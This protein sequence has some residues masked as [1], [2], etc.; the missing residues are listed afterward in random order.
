MLFAIAYFIQAIHF[1]CYAEIYANQ[2]Q[3]IRQTLEC[4][5]RIAFSISHNDQAAAPAYQ[6]INSHVFNVAAIGE[7]NK[8]G[9]VGDQA[10]KFLE[11]PPNSNTEKPANLHPDIALFFIKIHG[12]NDP[13]SQPDIEYRQD[14]SQRRVGMHTHVR[15]DCCTRCCNCRGEACVLLLFFQLARPAIPGDTATGKEAGHE[16]GFGMPALAEILGKLCCIQGGV[17]QMKRANLSG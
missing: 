2:A 12:I 9:F 13:V 14:K 17:D 4:I 6:F 5:F 11:E 8:A 7:I 3:R 1:D 16:K 15:T 10:E